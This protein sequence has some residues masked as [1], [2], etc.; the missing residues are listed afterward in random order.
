MYGPKKLQQCLYFEYLQFGGRTRRAAAGRKIESRRGGGCVWGR[1]TGWVRR[2]G[3]AG[4]CAC[5]RACVCECVCT[6]KL[7]TANVACTSRFSI[8]NVMM[9]RPAGRC[10][11]MTGRR[12]GGVS[13]PQKRL[14]SE[15]LQ[16]GEAA[17]M[18]LAY[19]ILEHIIRAPAL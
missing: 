4:G 16:F 8:T 18:I 14:H 10:V 19:I 5:V 13:G 7:L 3:P 2:T 17:A 15:R 6:S 1:G 9:H 12:G 11:W